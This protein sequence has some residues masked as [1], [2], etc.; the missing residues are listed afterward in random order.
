V[1]ELSICTSIASIVEQHAAGRTV[2][3]VRL[4]VGEMRQIVPQTLCYSW[5]IVVEGTPLAGS[6]LEVDHVPAVIA[7]ATC[8]ADTTLD[9]PV[10]RCP[11]G[12]TDVTLTSGQE[13]L[14]TSLE[15]T[16]G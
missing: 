1:H 10:L 7:C 8:G 12:S 6:R 3:R 5:E 15:L 11:C 9:R 16:G 13:L 4:R 14:V 2:E